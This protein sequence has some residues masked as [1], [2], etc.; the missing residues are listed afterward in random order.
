VAII[1]IFICPY[2]VVSYDEINPKQRGRLLYFD[3]FLVSDGIFDLFMGFDDVDGEPEKKVINVIKGN[4][5]WRFFM[6]IFI[7]FVP[8]ILNIYFREE[9]IFI[10]SWVYGLFKIFRYLR[11]SEFDS[12][13]EDIKEF[14]KDS[15]TE[16][17]LQVMNRNFD[18]CNFGVTTLVNLHMLTCAM[19]MLSQAKEEFQDSW[20][21]G[22]GVE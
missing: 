19:V 22:A 7:S 15:K 1:Y 10:K 12:L 11:L 17:E 20:L 8:N 21:G 3:L 9:R 5:S 13:F 4:L 14:H 6:E 18:I 16:H 2:I